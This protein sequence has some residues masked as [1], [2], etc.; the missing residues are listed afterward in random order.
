MK[1]RAK[2]HCERR[3]IHD[4]GTDAVCVRMGWPEKKL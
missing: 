1:A 3:S 4:E 2:I